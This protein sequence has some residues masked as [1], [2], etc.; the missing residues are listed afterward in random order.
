MTYN[1]F[2]NGIICLLVLSYHVI[3][4]L[5]VR[6]TWN[7]GY[8]LHAFQNFMRSHDY[9]VYSLS[10]DATLSFEAYFSLGVYIMI[11]QISWF[12]FLSFIYLIS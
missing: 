6:N 9:S 2:N 5:K 10:I 11:G 7:I 8:L 12:T 4:H 1:L 3:L